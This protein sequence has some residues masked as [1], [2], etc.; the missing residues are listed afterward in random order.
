MVNRRNHT[1]NKNLRHLRRAGLVCREH[2][3]TPEIAFR[4]AIK[5]RPLSKQ[6][7]RY[8]FEKFCYNLFRQYVA[9]R[10]ILGG[11]MPKQAQAQG[12]VEELP[13]SEP[14]FLILAS[15]A[16][17]PKHGYAILKEVAELSQGRVQLSTGTLYGAIKRL[18]EDSWIQRAP[19]PEPVN[20]NRERKS[21]ALTPHGW[22]VLGAESQRMQG[23]AELALQRMAGEAGHAPD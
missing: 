19:D 22:R 20:G 13:L 7:A 5:N 6:T 16:P 15:L 12:V 4:L 3:Q 8:S 18:L 10:H 11:P 14:V 1:R 2:P 23:L 17:G 21:Y 9:A